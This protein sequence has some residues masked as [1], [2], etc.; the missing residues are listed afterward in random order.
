MSED[1]QPAMEQEDVLELL[2]LPAE[3]VTAIAVP[4]DGQG[5]IERRDGTGMVPTVQAAAAAAGGFVAGAAVV[6]LVH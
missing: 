3:E 5:A 2:P 1:E 6:G 4:V